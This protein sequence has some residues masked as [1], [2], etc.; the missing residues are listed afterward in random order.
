MLTYWVGGSEKVQKYADVI[1]GSYGSLDS[2]DWEGVCPEEDVI[3]DLNKKDKNHTHTN[4]KGK[5][6]V[7]NVKGP[8]IKNGL[9]VIVDKL[10]CGWLSSSVF[11]GIK[12]ENEI[13][14]I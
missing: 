9:T 10:P 1:N 3:D 2:N 11:D 8:G 7:T 14:V 12:V 4:S 13:K 5:F 6:N